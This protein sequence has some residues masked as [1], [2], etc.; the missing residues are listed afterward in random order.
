MTSALLLGQISRLAGCLVS[1][2]CGAPQDF[3]K[4]ACYLD[5]Y[6]SVVDSVERIPWPDDRP[7]DNGQDAHT[8]ESLHLAL[9]STRVWAVVS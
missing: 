9:I 1:A 4:A 8:I 5:V 2:I 7:R 3:N 6:G